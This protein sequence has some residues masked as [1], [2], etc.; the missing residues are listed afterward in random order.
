LILRREELMETPGYSPQA[1]ALVVLRPGARGLVVN[2]APELLPPEA[3]QLLENVRVDRDGRLRLRPGWVL[4]FTLPSSGPVHSL[5]RLYLPSSG[6]YVAFVGSGTVLWRGATPATMQAVNTVLSGNPLVMLPYRPAISGDPW[7]IVGDTSV[8]GQVPPSGEAMLLGLPAPDVVCSTRIVDILTTKICDF[9]GAVSQATAWTMTAGVDDSVPKAQGAGAPVAADITGIQGNAVE[10]T[11]NIGNALKGYTSIMGLPVTMDLTTLQGGFRA[12]GQDDIIHMWIR[13]SRP[14]IVE[15]VRVYLV[16]SSG[17]SPSVVPGQHGSLNTDAFVHAFRPSDITGFLENKQ[18]GTAAAEQTQR[19]QVIDEYL[20]L[21]DEDDS[22]DAKDGVRRRFPNDSTGRGTHTSSRVPDEMAPGRNVWT[23]FGALGKPLRRSDFER[24]GTTTG[25]GWGTITGIVIVIK[26][27][28]NEVVSLACDDWYLTGG[29]GLDSSEPGAA[30]YDYRYT[31]YHLDTGDEGNPSPIQGETSRLF[32]MRQRTAILPTAYTG[33][34]STR[35]RQRFYRRGGTITD[36]WYYV[37]QNTANGAEFVDTLE[38][39]EIAAAPTLEIDNYQP[40]P[41]VDTQG[42][43]VKAAVLPAVWGPHDGAIYGCGD[44]YRPGHLYRS[45]TGRPG[46]WPPDLVVEV[47]SPSEELLNGFVHSGQGFVFSRRRLFLISANAVTGGAM[48]VQDTPCQKGLAGRWAF[49][50]GPEGIAFISDDGIYGTDGGGPAQ[51]LSADI[52]PL[53]FGQ[54]TI[55]AVAINLASETNLRLF[56]GKGTLYFQYLGLDGNLHQLVCAR[57]GGRLVWSRDVMPATPG[58]FYFDAENPELPP[59]LGSGDAGPATIYSFDGRDDDGVPI[60]AQYISPELSFDR[61]REEKQLGDLMVETDGLGAAG[62]SVAV[63]LDDRTILPTQTITGADQQQQ[64]VLV[65]PDPGVEHRFRSARI[66]VVLPGDTAGAAPELRQ[67]QFTATPLVEETERRMGVWEPLGKNGAYLTGVVITCDTR[68]NVLARTDNTLGANTRNVQIEYSRGGGA[69]GVLGPYLIDASQ[70]RRN[71]YLSW[72]GVI[73]DQVRIVPLDA[74][75]WLLYA[76]KWQATDEP[77]SQGVWDSGEEILGDTYYTGLDLVVRGEGVAAIYVDNQLVSTYDFRTTSTEPSKVTSTTAKTYLHHTFG[78]GYGHIY[79]CVIAAGAAGVQ[80]YA[81]KWLAAPVPGEQSNWNRNFELAG[82]LTEKMVKGVLLECDTGGLTKTV[83]VQA[84]GVTATTLSVTANGRQVL[85][86]SFP[87]F[88]AR[89]LRMLPT[90]SALS[91]LFSVQWIFDEEP[92][93]LARWETQLL[94][95]GQ[96]DYH[97]IFRLIVDYRAAAAVTLTIEGYTRDGFRAF[98]HEYLLPA[99]NERVKRVVSVQAR[100]AILWK[101]TFTSATPFNLYREGCGI[102]V[103]PLSG[104]ERQDISAPFGNDDLDHGRALGNASGVA[105][106]PN[107]GA[108]E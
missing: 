91:R 10:F 57:N 26:T 12:A 66:H 4:Q 42:N 33:A 89:V 69:V 16:C 43:T 48:A 8:L 78:P 104:E 35:V 80:V 106:T 61:P 82:T 37:G 1:A 56:W 60:T 84:D 13:L 102:T 18:S 108:L 63:T 90:D 83:D 28:T 67:L 72:S 99:A 59:Y 52:R 97:S 58:A 32:P 93:A 107:N 95:H 51:E 24:I 74:N 22:D 36:D 40:V 101:Y 44:R 77:P 105:S 19:T 23:E 87:Q 79:R 50:V 20:R 53:W 27:T 14:G 2:A 49:A 86:L 46:S 55:G 76:L 39:L 88:R 65:T 47:C 103:I 62:L 92:L 96:R 64:R 71:I 34:G 41:T 30:S 85:H 11:T 17:F 68:E 9:H 75:P 25:R 81:H 45:K 94:D 5:A 100:M 7:M 38:D 98:Q 31:H 21:P 54:T 73:A 6:T 3:A 29:Y 15:E 70:G